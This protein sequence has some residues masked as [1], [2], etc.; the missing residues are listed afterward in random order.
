[1]THRDSVSALGTF[2][3]AGVRTGLVILGTDACVQTP[4]ST[5]SSR[6]P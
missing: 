4:S 1:M 6:W 2:I 3:M 5:W